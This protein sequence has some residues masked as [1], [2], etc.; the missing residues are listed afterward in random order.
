M[1]LVTITRDNIDQ[2]MKLA[3]EFFYESDNRD[4]TL[5]A[6]L[7]KNS[8]LDVVDYPLH[9]ILMVT[10]DDGDPGGYIIFYATREYTVEMIGEVY[11]FFVSHRYRGTVAS[12]T[13]INA[14]M[15]QYKE[16]GVKRGYVEIA[17]GIDEINDKI[18]INL[19]GK[20]GYK[21]SG[22]MMTKEF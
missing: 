8:L 3:V 17:S 22:F 7:Y 13:L 14:A 16:W 18:F 21:K 19:W 6:E 10:D 15:D 20:F 1:K 2:M 5:D 11:H 9:K 12:R 4:L